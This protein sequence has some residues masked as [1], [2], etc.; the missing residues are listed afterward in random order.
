MGDRYLVT[1]ASR[2][3]GA[4]FVQ[5][6]VGRGHTVVAA[7]R[8]PDGAGS[9]A[10]A[11]AKVVRLDVA[12][13]ETFEA[14]ARSLD[15]PIDLLINNAGVATT[16]ASVRSMTAETFEHVF[17]TNVFGLALLT[18]ALLPVLG[19][20][21]RKTV[22]NVSSGL[23]SLAGTPGGFSYAYCCSKAALNMLTVL[24]HKELAGEGFTVISLDPGW[25]RTDMGGEQA[26]LDPK[27]TVAG[28]VTLLEGLK[29]TDSGKFLG[30][31]GQ[32][33]AW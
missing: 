2:G 8:D 30:Y 14:F 17:R 27:E 25:N 31:D 7:V 23:G 15:G 5:Q 20:G 24:M 10:R 21:E 26:P 11:G 9:A 19:R 32:I 18:R 33:R 13:P 28:M 22:A 12:R 6:L 29:A 4:E 1:G 16:D 3:L